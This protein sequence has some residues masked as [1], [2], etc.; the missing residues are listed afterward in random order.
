MTGAEIIPQAYAKKKVAGRCELCGSQD[1]SIA[2]DLK[3]LT[4]TEQDETGE[5]AAM[6]NMP[7]VVMIC[8]HCGNVRMHA[9]KVLAAD[10][11]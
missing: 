10:G 2:D 7:V 9:L 6:K 8:R 4:F 11:E 3:Y 5:L 1:W